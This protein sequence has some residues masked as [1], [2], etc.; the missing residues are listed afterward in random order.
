MS[1]EPTGS[2]STSQQEEEQ[3]A[4]AESLSTGVEQNGKANVKEKEVTVAEAG[5]AAN[6]EEKAAAVEQNKEEEEA[7]AQ[8]KKEE[9]EKAAAQ[10]GKEKEEAA[11]QKKKTKEEEE[12]ASEEFLVAQ[13]KKMQANQTSGEMTTDTAVPI[14]NE[15]SSKEEGPESTN[16]EMKSLSDTEEKSKIEVAV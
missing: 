4:L 13:A 16:V 9:E 14:Q 1:T 6:E 12:K 15:S 11:A 7:A 8:K 10:K 5:A 3:K 2:A